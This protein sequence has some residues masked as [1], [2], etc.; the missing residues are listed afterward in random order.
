[1][2]ISQKVNLILEA[3][4]TI[5]FAWHSQTLTTSIAV[6]PGTEQLLAKLSKNNNISQCSFI[7]KEAI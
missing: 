4:N 2:N 1:L 6:T 7:Q 3:V 5:L